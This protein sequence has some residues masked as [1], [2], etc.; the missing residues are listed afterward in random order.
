MGWIPGF[1]KEMGQW[2]SRHPS[3]L[4][5]SLNAFV[6]SMISWGPE[7]EQFGTGVGSL[8]RLYSP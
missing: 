3:F 6:G 1:C 4:G 5:V 2:V 7:D 8:R